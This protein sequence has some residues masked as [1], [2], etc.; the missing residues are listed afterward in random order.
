MKSI[1]L[2][3]LLIL[4]LVSGRCSGGDGAVRQFFE[5]QLHEVFNEL[6]QKPEQYQQ[7]SKLRQL[8]EEYIVDFWD[9]DA[10]LLA[11]VGRSRWEPLSSQQKKA[12]R[13]AFRDT[14]TRYFMEAHQYYS[15]Q[16]VTLQ[17]IQLNNEGDKG[18]L[19][20][21]IELDYMPDLTVD[22]SLIKQNQQWMFRDIRFKGIRYT[23]MK[24]GYYQGMLEEFGFDKLL[25]DLNE[26]N[27]AYFS[28][29]GLAEKS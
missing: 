2:I 5:T 24:R 16:P 23:R 3:L 18:W 21:A 20:I 10:T 12:L 22:L 15:G 9:V 19:T 28:A 26:K 11:M 29:L 14:L 27:E 1:S 13:L 7:A 17:S 25:A 6:K 8:A 4:S